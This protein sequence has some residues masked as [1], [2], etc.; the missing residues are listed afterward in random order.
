MIVMARRRPKRMCDRLIQIPPMKIQMMFIRVDRQPDAPGFD[1]VVFPNG[2]RASV[3]IF[4][5]WMPNGIPMIVMM[6]RRLAITYSIAMKMPPNRSQMMLP[7][8][9]IAVLFCSS[10]GVLLY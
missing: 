8:V 4:R 6:S 1:T 10:S 3:A 7:R 2:Q 9:F 5:V